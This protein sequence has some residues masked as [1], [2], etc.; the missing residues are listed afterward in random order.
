[1][2]NLFD[3][4][5]EEKVIYV[6]QQ[7]PKEVVAA[8]RKQIPTSFLGKIKQLHHTSLNSKNKDG[9]INYGTD[10]NGRI[11]SHSVSPYAKTFWSNIEQ[12]IKPLVEA[13]YNKMFL[14]IS[15]CEGHDYTSRRFVAVVLPSEDYAK[16]LARQIGNMTFLEYDIFHCSKYMNQ[17]LDVNE[18]INKVK[19]IGRVEDGMNADM[20]VVTLNA[21]YHRGYDNYYV[22]E[23]IIGK[24]IEKEDPWYLKLGLKFFKYFLQKKWTRR[25]IKRINSDRV[26]YYYE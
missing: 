4:I 8:K 6:E 7:K 2:R 20:A 15:S 24:E 5:R 23:I 14:T 21:M 3:P 9:R 12:G 22:L 17:V 10:S 11:L 18:K 25:V 26:S 16:L 19:D 1:M 13:L